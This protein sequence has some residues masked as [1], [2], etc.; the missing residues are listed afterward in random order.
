MPRVREALVT[1]VGETIMLQVLP[2][3]HADEK[4]APVAL[5]N[6]GPAI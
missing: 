5:V 2:F 6:P 3:T 1:E 4:R